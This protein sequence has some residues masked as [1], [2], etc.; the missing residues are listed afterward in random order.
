MEDKMTDFYGRVTE[1]QDFFKKILEKIPGFS[2]YV[3]RSNRR[4]ADKMLRDTIADRFES[5]W[6]RISEL[7]RQII[8]GGEIEKIDD[9]EAAAIKL[10][11][12]IDRIRTAAYGYAGFFDAVKIKEEELA[13]IYEYDLQLLDLEA[14]IG[15]AID[16]IESSMGT[17]GL[18]AAI[19]HL[20][21]LTQNCVEAFE[22]RKE[23]LLIGT[24]SVS[25]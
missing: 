7:Q 24:D 9:I 6:Q 18:P 5:L 12:F 14:E 8:S 11:Q 17:D 2:G 22:K 19:R 16:N 20:V 1:E 3:E 13:N 23:T 4:A 10:R 15:R 21:T 25:S